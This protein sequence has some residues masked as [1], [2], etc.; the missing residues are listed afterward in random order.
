MEESELSTPE[1]GAG[2]EAETGQDLDIESEV[3]VELEV[4]RTEIES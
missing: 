4:T 3:D 2:T 1:T